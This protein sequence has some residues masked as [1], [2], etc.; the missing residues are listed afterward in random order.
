MFK[1]RKQEEGQVGH[2][3]HSSSYQGGQSLPHK[4]PSQ[5]LY[6]SYSPEL[7]HVATPSCKRVWKSHLLLDEWHQICPIALDR[8]LVPL[9]S[10]F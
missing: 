1:D 6:A 2:S 5:H 10:P 9:T 8:Y 7:A 3:S 4:P